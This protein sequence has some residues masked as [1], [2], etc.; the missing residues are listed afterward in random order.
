MKTPPPDQ[1]LRQ[2]VIELKRAKAELEWNTAFLEAQVNSSIDG[3]L[4]VDA[5]GKKILQNAS[6]RPAC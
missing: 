5:A 6:G 3:I 2:S 1:E 4:V